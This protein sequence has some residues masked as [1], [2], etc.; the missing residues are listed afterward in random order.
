MRKLGKYEVLGELGHG[1]MGV[2]YRARDPIINR[3]VALKTIT[4]AAADDPNLL[5]RFYR[6]AQSAGGL[7]HPN[8]VTIYDMGDEQNLPY[9]AM[10]LIEGESLEQIIS[11]RANIAIALKLA[12]AAQACRAFDYAHKRGIIHRDIKPGNVM[13]SNEGVVKVV[14]FGIARVLD[15]S[16]TRTGMLIGTFAYMS[17]EQY[18]GERADERSDIWS[19]GVLLYELMCYQRPFAGDSPA[20][21]MRSI[22][23]EEPPALSDLAPDCPPELGIILSK[24][25]RKS[26]QDRCQSMEDLLLELEPVCKELQSRSIAELIKESRQIIDQGEFARARE[27]L[28]EALKVDSANPQARALLEKVNA[29]LKRLLIRPKVQQHVDRGRTLLEEG[30]IQEARV[31]VENALQLD[32]SSE[33]AQELEKSV[34][35]ELDRA[36][37]VAEWLQASRQQLAE[38]LPDEAA[39]MLAKVL[40]ADPANNQAKAL[41]QQALMEKAESQRRLRLLE[42]L[43]EARGLWNQ[44]DFEPCIALLSRLLEDYPS[45]EEIQKL[46]ETVREDQTEQYRRRVLETVRNLL[47]GGNHAECR[48]RLLELQK[49]FPNEDEV[50]RLLEEVQLDE[51]KQRRLQGLAE[52]RNRLVTSRFEESIALL[53][54]LEKDFPND[55]E[56]PRLLKIAREDQAEQYKQKGIVEARNLLASR[57]YED[58]NTHL[59]RMQKQFPNDAE[60]LDLLNA[61]RLGQAK[62]RKLDAL[63]KARNLLAAR[64]YDECLALLA[65]LAK[66]FPED[67]EVPKLLKIACEDQ[68]EQCRLKSLTEAKNLLALGSYD[69]AVSLLTKLNTEFPGV[70]EITKLLATAGKEQAEQRKQQRLAEGKKLLAGQRFLEAIELLD[71]LLPAYPNDGAIQKLRALVKREQDKQVRLDKLQRELQSLKIQVSEKKYSDILAR[72]GILQA[73]FPGEPDVTRLIDFARAQQTQ[74]ESETRLRKVIDEVKGHVRLNRFTEAIRAAGAGLEA[75]PND[76]ELHF[77]R[78]QAE[79]EEKKQR[80]RGLIEQRIRGIKFKIN[81]EDLSD[82]VQLAKETLATTGPNAE[83]TQLLNCALVEIQAREKKRAQ[84][85]KLQEI[86]TL[87]ESGDVNAAADTL[88]DSVTIGTLDAYDPRVHRLSHEIDTA[89]AGAIVA[90]AAEAPSERPPAN[91]S[92]E[93]AFQQAKPGEPEPPPT[94]TIGPTATSELQASSSHPVVSHQPVVPLLPPLTFHPIGSASAAAAPAPAYEASSAPRTAPSLPVAPTVPPPPA[95]VRER[96]APILP[97]SKPTPR[98]WNITHPI[99]L[100]WILL[101]LVLAVWAG[102]HFRATRVTMVRTSPVVPVSVP[103][104]GPVVPPQ[105]KVDPTE[106]QQRKAIDAAD[107]L[108]VSGD[109]KG[110]LVVLKNAEK[111]NGPLSAEIRRKEATIDESM[112]NA[113]LAKL[114]R[115]EE[116]LWQQ[117][118]NEADRAEFDA[119][120]QDLRKI[121]GLGSGGVRRADAQRYLEQVIPRRQNEEELYDQAKTKSQA[122]DVQ[123]LKSA[124]TLLG[125]LIAL[126]GPRKPD[127]EALLNRVHSTLNNLIA[128]LEASARQSIQ[129]RNFTAAR[130]KADQIRE[131]GGDLAPLYREID[132]AEQAEKEFQQILR[133]YNSIDAKDSNALQKSRGEFGAIAR[134]NGSRASDAQNYVNEID[135]KLLVLKPPPPPPPKPPPPPDEAIRSVIQSFVQAFEHKDPAAMKQVWP[136]MP[137]KKYTEYIRVFGMAKIINLQLLN[138]TLTV[139]PDGTTAAFS[140]QVDQQFTPR[141]GGKSMSRRDAWAFQLAKRNGNWIITD[142]Q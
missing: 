56:I 29:E 21:L 48:S 136:T 8:I 120:T 129:Q 125:Q 134:G 76:T 70:H 46:L 110:A 30:K 101:G 135:G 83:V 102:I 57:R 123:N 87:M 33:P 2:V 71:S 11:R 67:E 91:L 7:Q 64:H 68:T 89:K 90:T 44:Q 17:P 113:S 51:V 69:E 108:V 26:R 59:A 112:Q 43:Q 15:T 31:E 20:S 3:L 139:S 114:R 12:Y 42:K 126:S 52:A 37:M 39:A 14:D 131:A 124:A 95:G 80:A 107:G 138:E 58:C 73:E 1:A 81:R 49:Q 9:I 16:K 25:L 122:S 92:M 47:A 132:Q 5:E 121:L 130:L 32:S 105:P 36:Q 111:L 74:I 77:L 10:Q 65:E 97:L 100:A 53:T 84:E 115:Q 18:Y 23:A 141:D 127:A 119:A 128:D 86:R 82:A 40:E 104:L 99:T 34:Q 50:H 45:E 94:D 41:Q 137:P 75:F 109:L 93:Y 78:E 142:A 60:I 4:S 66:D 103:L 35:R 24:T 61:V 63:M 106:A 22:C 98:V 62:Q 96:G 117:A 6:E 72:A 88:S 85:Q 140:A 38:G 54:D 116:I 133:A 27:L 13:V 19:F 118:T 55:E 79:S 28:R